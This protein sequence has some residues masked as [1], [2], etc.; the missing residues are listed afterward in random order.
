[1]LFTVFTPVYNRRDLIYRVWDSLRAQT[2]RD[3]E[4]I[5][6]DDGSADN[7]AELIAQYAREADFPIIFR[8]QP[9]GGKHIAWNRGVELAR[10]ELFVSADSDDGFIPT[11]LERFKFWWQSVSEAERQKL[12]GIN[13]LCQDPGTGAVIGSLY[14]QSPMLSQNLELAHVH[15]MSGEKWG[16]VRT[17]LLRQIPFPEDASLRRNYLSENYLWLRL[18]RAHQ[19]L[20][21]NEPLRLYYRDAANSLMQQAAAASLLRR[22]LP[23]RYFYKSWH[24]NTNLDYLRRDPK[25]LV[26]TALDIWISG[27][28]MGKSVRSILKDGKAAMPW[29]IRLASAPVG[30]AALAYLQWKARGNK[31]ITTPPAAAGGPEAISRTAGSADSAPPAR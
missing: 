20:C 29:L 11:A 8:T 6:V 21:V 17:D 18:A 28:A 10:G 23:T 13:V 14:P 24:L 30:I 3:F 9:N 22:G 5:I 15:R 1:L 4:W 26:K 2:F 12:S 25:E 16:V 7:V 19:V 27:L 31:P